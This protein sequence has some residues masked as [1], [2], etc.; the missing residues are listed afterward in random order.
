MEPNFH[1]FFSSF[2]YDVERQLYKLRMLRFNIFIS[3]ESFSLGCV[4]TWPLVF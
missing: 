4:L 2:A 3:F 1:D